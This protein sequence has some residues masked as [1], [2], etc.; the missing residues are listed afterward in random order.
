VALGADGQ[1]EGEEVGEAVAAGR[2]EG[3]SHRG[4][5][6]VGEALA[7][8]VAAAIQVG[9][10]VDAGRTLGGVEAQRIA[11][12]IDV[13]LVVIGGEIS[14]RHLPGEEDGAYG[15]ASGAGG[16]DHRDL[17]SIVA[18]NAGIGGGV[19]GVLVAG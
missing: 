8:R 17:Q 15:T 10:A 3:G 4:I 12:T 18:T 1:T 5:V 2:V 13:V 14:A 7:V 6:G 19:G 16:T 9:V 11:R